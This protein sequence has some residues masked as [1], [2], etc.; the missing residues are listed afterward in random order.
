MMPKLNTG[1]YRTVTYLKKSYLL[2]LLLAL[3]FVCASPLK[4][5][6]E[7]QPT[8]DQTY[9][10]AVIARVDGIEITRG[11]LLNT[12]NEILPYQAYHASVGERQYEK[13]QKKA[14][15]KLILNELVY[16]SAQEQE[17]D[18]VDELEIVSSIEAIKKRL[19]KTDTLE[20][21]LERSNMT[22][23]DLRKDIRK[24]IL[25]REMNKKKLDE[26]RAQASQTVNDA[27][28]KNYYD[29]T[30]EKFKEPERMR[31]S[32]ILIKADRSGGQR[33]W[34]AA[35]KKAR[36]LAER[37]RNGED[38]AELAKQYSEGPNAANGGSMGWAH[39]GS[40]LQ[41]LDYAASKLKKGEVSGPVM[42]IYGYHVL[43]LDDIKPSTLK[44]YEEVNKKRLKKDLEEKEYKRLRESWE[45]GLLSR[46]NIE[47][48][49]EMY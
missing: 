4:L 35:K 17:Q 10:N 39:K 33:V 49:R 14:M 47:Y 34:N 18:P 19:T 23:E 13:L 37:T 29:N 45:T 9:K 26:F 43:K 24:S 46:A 11:Q 20:K 38:F 40:L 28:M 5:G 27:Y 31:L 25:V 12:I 21:A 8:Q 22:M 3:I 32:N 44:K 36:E 1:G 15:D 6:A 41:E 2:P 42:T 48:L 30:L 16:K 7:E